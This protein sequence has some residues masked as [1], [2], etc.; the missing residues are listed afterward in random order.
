VLSQVGYVPYENLIGRA[1]IIFFSLEE[2]ARFWQFWK[3]PWSIR[4]ERLFQLVD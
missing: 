4:W 1:D 3:W 2:D